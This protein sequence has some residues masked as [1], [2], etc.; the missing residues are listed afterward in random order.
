MT[1]YLMSDRQSSG[2]RIFSMTVSSE[3]HMFVVGNTVNL[4]FTLLQ[5]SLE[6]NITLRK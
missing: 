6:R 4:D 5:G 3:I 1:Y 2:A